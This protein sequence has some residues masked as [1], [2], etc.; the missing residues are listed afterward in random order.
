MEQTRRKP[1]SGNQGAAL[2]ETGQP[3]PGG[4][5]EEQVPVGM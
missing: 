3:A 2:R 4:E 1:G 5:E